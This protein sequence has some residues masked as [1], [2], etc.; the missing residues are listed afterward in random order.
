M[1]TLSLTGGRRP[2]TQDPLPHWVAHG[3]WRGNMSPEVAVTAAPLH[4]TLRCRHAGSSPYPLTLKLRDSGCAFVSAPWFSHSV[5]H[6][7]C[8]KN[9]QTAVAQSGH[10]SNQKSEIDRRPL[11]CLQDNPSSA[12]SFHVVPS[13]LS[14]ILV[15]HFAHHWHGS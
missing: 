2:P 4:W 10:C 5:L 9:M 12:A 15:I 1:Q 8:K 3:S 7:P 11:Q 13:K 6:S 14:H